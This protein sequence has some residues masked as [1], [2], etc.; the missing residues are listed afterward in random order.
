M[1][2]VEREAEAAG[3]VLGQLAH[4]VVLRTP[5]VGVD[6]LDPV[7]HLLGLGQLLHHDQHGRAVLA[8]RAVEQDEVE[9]AKVRLPGPERCDDARVRP[10][11]DLHVS[12]LLDRIVPAHVGEAVGAPLLPE[13]VVVDRGAVA[14]PRL[15]L[16]CRL[17]HLREEGAA[18]LR[19]PPLARLLLRRRAG[20]V[21][22]D[23]REQRELGLC[24]GLCGA[25]EKRREPGR[26]GRL[27][28]AEEV[29]EA[30]AT[31]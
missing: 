25:A 8:A 28:G 18:P 16:R 20:I 27:R 24:R 3:L 2:D 17:K 7:E 21:A 15:A 22:V 11:L 23:R 26:C 9:V 1:N 30:H 10:T 4:P 19:V 5:E 31:P 14:R 13:R 29:G 12:D 6:D